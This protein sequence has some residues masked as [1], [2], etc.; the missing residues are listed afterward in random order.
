MKIII[1]IAH[2]DDEVIGAGGSILKWVKDGHIVNVIYANN[3]IVV[4]GRNGYDY[5][6]HAFLMSKELGVKSAQ[7]LNIPTMEFDKYGQLELNKRFD[8]LGFNYDMIV[9][10]SPSDVNKDHQVVYESARVMCR[11]NHVKLLCCDTLGYNTQFVPNFFMDI[12]DE[13]KK[14]LDILRIIGDE[15]REYPHE[16][17]FRA[18]KSRAE[19]WGSK[20]GYK[21]AEA[22]D[23]KKWTV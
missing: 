12:S 6:Q 10:H 22:F 14:K 21:Y 16:R 17:S 1:Y 20:V 11:Y 9:T 18:L 5:R 4:H 13:I 23:C 2:V 7:F 8:A 3:G 15:M 19:F